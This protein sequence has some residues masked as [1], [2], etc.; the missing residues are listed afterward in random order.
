MSASSRGCRSGAVCPVGR[1]ATIPDMRI[2]LAFARGY[3]VAVA[4]DLDPR[5]TCWEFPS[6][7]QVDPTSVGPLE[8]TVTWSLTGGPEVTA[9]A[10]L[11]PEPVRVVVD[12]VAGPSWWGTICGRC[13][14]T[15][16]RCSWRGSTRRETRSC[17]SRSTSDQGAPS[18][19]LTQ[20]RGFARQTRTAFDRRTSGVWWV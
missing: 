10:V 1:D 3:S 12:S 20:V 7:R 19:L 18:T 13:S 9:P 11:L 4:E 17:R 2:D 14:L 15:G 5:A 6:G 16:R 8:Q